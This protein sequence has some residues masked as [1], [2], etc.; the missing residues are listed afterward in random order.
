MQTKL[1]F[2]TLITSYSCLVKTILFNSLISPSH[3]NLLYFLYWRQAAYRAQLYRSVLVMVRHACAEKRQRGRAARHSLGV[4]CGF[5]SRLGNDSR[6]ISFHVSLPCL[7]NRISEGTSQTQLRRG[8]CAK[9]NLSRSG[10]HQK[11]KKRLRELTEWKPE[12]AWL[13]V[14]APGQMLTA[15]ASLV[16][17]GLLIEVAMRPALL[18]E[19][20][21]HPHGWS[22][23][24]LDH[25][26]Q[27]AVVLSTQSCR[28][29][30]NNSSH[31]ILK[32]K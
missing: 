17:N 30:T 11:K 12:G 29:R 16:A 22:E 23:V 3:Y 24:R 21:L 13:R 5:L 6:E 25:S 26:T 1:F 4:R 27:E 2:I 18:R 14:T 9:F 8:S 10:T 15:S 32:N 31:Q 20:R 28:S 19:N 7:Q